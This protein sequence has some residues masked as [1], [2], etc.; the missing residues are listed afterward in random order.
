M[1]IL[2]LCTA[3]N[4][5]S[6]Q[7]YLELS[8]LGHDISI[9]CALS[10]ESMLE[11][12]AL[13]SPELVLCPFLTTRVPSEIYNKVMTLI[14]HPGPPGDAGPSAL[15]WLL[16]GDDGS[17]ED[18]AQALRYLGT[19]TTLVLDEVIGASPSSQRLKTSMLDRCG[20]LSSFRLT[21]TNAD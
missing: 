17:I 11:A 21:S 16:M 3:H 20:P 2:F 12:V 8:S 19:L 10:D 4:S 7:L 13:F 18:A 5:L 9:E 1:K 6:Q 14:I 15:D